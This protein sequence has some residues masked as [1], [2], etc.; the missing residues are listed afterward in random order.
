MLPRWNKRLA[1]WGSLHIQGTGF[2]C[3]H[4]SFGGSWA[5]FEETL[6]QQSGRWSGSFNTLLLASLIA[7]PAVGATSLFEDR[8]C[9]SAGFLWLSTS[10]R[11][12]SCPTNDKPN[13]GVPFNQNRS[14]IREKPDCG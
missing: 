12:Q 14:Q 13:A 6:E 1:E 5:A 7:K 3:Q 9:L 8:A 4:E 11:M 2:S 10:G